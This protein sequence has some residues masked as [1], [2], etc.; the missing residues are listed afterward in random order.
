MKYIKADVFSSKNL[1]NYSQTISD[2]QT[3]IVCLEKHAPSFVHSVMYK[4][5]Q[6]A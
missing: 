5:G 3:I 2:Y 4:L 6:D 1:V